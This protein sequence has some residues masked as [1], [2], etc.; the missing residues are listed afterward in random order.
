[1]RQPLLLCNPMRYKIKAP[2]Q[3]SYERLK[4]ELEGRLQIKVDLPKRRMIS[5]DD[6]SDY[7]KRIIEDYGASLSIAHKYGL[8]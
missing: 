4:R 3:D 1:V 6:L 2:D 7:D 5:V 8:G